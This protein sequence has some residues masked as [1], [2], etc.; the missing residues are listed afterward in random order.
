[1]QDTIG[2]THTAVLEHRSGSRRP[3]ELTAAPILSSSGFAGLVFAF[4]DVSRKRMVEAELNRAQKLEAVGILAGGI[5]HDFNNL[6]TVLLGNVSLL[7][8]GGRLDDEEIALLGDAETALMRA[9]DLTHQLLTFS[10]G[11]APVRE[12]ASISEVIHD[13]VSFVLAG[14]TVR[15]EVD[16]EPDLMVVEIDAG[17]ISQVLN[18]LLINA[19]QAM[20]GGG[21]VQVVG[22]NVT[23]APRPLT[24]GHYVRIDIVDGGVGIP[25]E[26]LPRVFD[27]YFSTKEEGRGLGLASAYS[28]IKNHDGLLTVDSEPGRGTTFHI[29]LPA[30]VDGV[31]L[32]NRRGHSNFRGHGRV[33]VMDD[34]A[35][36]RRTSGVMLERLGF[37][38]AFAEDGQRALDLYGSGG[39]AR[40]FDLVMMD[41]T[42]PG[43]MGGQ[44]AMRRLL[45]IDPDVRAIV[46]SGYSN[47]PVLANYRDYGFIGQAKR[48][49]QST[50]ES[51]VPI[52]GQD[53]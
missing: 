15:G 29:F 46:Y 5:A 43:G 9:R 4:R 16:L 13:S 19:T 18:N 21:R 34:D 8:E 47:D 38:V 51:V 44:E 17:Q 30:T 3:V 26:L 33:L 37:E 12:A 41:L 31:V 24:R 22:R 53:R 35:V 40:T 49:G 2:P 14:S 42:V 11:G 39:A 20:P 36:V 27:P 45:E 7:Q 10:R 52:V 32:A 25:E 6:L 50:D 23:D 28:I 1:L 48:F